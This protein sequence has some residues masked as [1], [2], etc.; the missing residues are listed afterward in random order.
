MFSGF[1]VPDIEQAKGFYGDTLGLTVK[2]KPEGLEL[3]MGTASVFIYSSADNKPADYTVLNFVV[4][5]IDVTMDEL[6][7]KGVHMEQ[8]DTPHMKTDAKGVVRS[9]G[10]SPGPK[11]IAWFKDPAGNILSVIQEK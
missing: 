11:A 9:D 3:T 5:N 6:I 1:S 8:Y 10:T 7:G 2:S 4:E